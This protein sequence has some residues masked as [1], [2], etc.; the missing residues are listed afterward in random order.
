M[1]M[2]LDY[3][4]EMRKMA[5][6]FFQDFFKLKEQR[7]EE[8]NI[9]GLKEGIWLT[10]IANIYLPYIEDG[11]YVTLQFGL[12]K[13]MPIDALMGVNFQQAARMTI[14]LGNNKVHSPVFRDEYRISWERP[15]NKPIESIAAVIEQQ[16]S[17]FVTQQEEE[18]VKME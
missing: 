13:K 9:G 12:S 11:T 3:A 1:M 16:N 17:V 5:P 10:H 2:N 6:Q 4:D 7:Y 8:I 15:R 18:V 14:D